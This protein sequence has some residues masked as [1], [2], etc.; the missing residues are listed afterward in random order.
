MV[1]KKTSNP[2]KIK[3]IGIGGYGCNCLERLKS[4]DDQGIERIAVSTYGKVFNRLKIKNKI[5]L[6]EEETSLKGKLDVESVD[7]LIRINKLDILNAVKG[8]D[9]VF[10]VGGLSRDIAPLIFQRTVELLKDNGILTFAITGK[11]FSFEGDRKKV[12]A[13]ENYQK[14]INVAD[15]VICINNDKLIIKGFKATDALAMA[16]KSLA[17][18]VYE[19]VEIMS[20]VG[21]INTDF[22]DFKSTIIDSGEAFFGTA[23]GSRDRLE[24]TLNEAI[25]NKYFETRFEGSERVL[26][27]ITADS[28]LSVREMKQIGDFIKEKASENA[29]IIFGLV[30]DDAMKDK[31]KI[32]I[33]SGGVNRS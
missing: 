4:L 29:R 1:K 7:E 8:A 11:P 21:E 6:G 2:I 12:I 19:L 17:N 25:E 9:L 18:Y 28:E 33:L 10:L 16:D 22:N 31:I 14:L 23:T 20:K 24:K 15:A 26:Y 3:V 13:D 30:L 27:V 32:T 5:A